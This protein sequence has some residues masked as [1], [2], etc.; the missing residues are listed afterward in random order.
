MGWLAAICVGDCSRQM[1][2]CS[3]AAAA[4]GLK[5][6]ERIIAVVNFFANCTKL[7]F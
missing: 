6:N 7:L 4:T 5:L 2:R 3:S 1:Q